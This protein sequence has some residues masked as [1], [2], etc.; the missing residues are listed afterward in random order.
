MVTNS[1]RVLRPLLGFASC[2]VLAG[3][4]VI[5]CDVQSES[6]AA[7]AVSQAG[8]SNKK[9]YS[10]YPR[11]AVLET[12]EEM[13]ADLALER[14]PSDGGGRGWLESGPSEVTVSSRNAWTLAF[15]VGPLGIAEGGV[16]YFMTSPFW[17]WDDHP[18]TFSSEQPGY[19]E[20]STEADGVELE[21]INFGQNLLG[22]KVTGRALV[23]GEVVRFRYGAGAV[24]ARADKFYERDARFWFAVDGDGDGV[25]K[26]VE[27]APSID[28]VTGSPSGLWV[29]IPTST[30]I[31]ESLR[32]TLALLDPRGNA[33]I[34]W[35]GDIVFEDVPAGLEVPERVTLG[36][37]SRGVAA[38]DF[39]A[40]KAGTYTLKAKLDPPLPGAPDDFTYDSNP[41]LASAN[42]R[43]ILWADLH[44]H[45]QLTD[46]TGTPDDFYLYARDVAALDIAVLTDHDHWGIHFLDQRP[47]LWEHIGEVANKY[48]EPGK[49]VSL[50]GYEWTSWIYGHRHV[51]YFTDKGEL[52]SSL[53]PE[54]EN[55]D[56]LW[57]KLKGKDALSFAHHSAG[58]PI[59]T[60]WSFEPDPEIEPVTEIVSVHGSS[61][62]PDSPQRIYRSIPGNFVRD[63]LDSGMRFGFIGSGDSHDG[64][65]GLAHL[66]APSGGLAAILAEDRTRESVL[67]ALRARRVY[68]TNGQRILLQVSVSGHRMGSTIPADQERPLELSVRVVGTG[69]IDA[70][71]FIWKNETQ[72][73]PCG[74]RTEIYLPPDEIDIAPGDYLY[75]RVRQ[76]DGGVAWSSPFYAD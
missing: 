56:Q 9:E 54:T 73:L 31:G 41:M 74:G 68:A 33:W 23:E 75:L 69:P 67:E 16:I 4:T 11:T 55:P 28:V 60:D 38:V 65:P 48:Y 10:G 59:A 37:E 63:V 61:E 21:A 5:A 46:G 7:K 53:A 18:Q 76:A 19:T 36:A 27:D 42:A 49:F 6:G 72:T 17:G 20:I 47:D 52:Y 70:I 62:A 15:E 24:G 12:L 66:A 13:R 64:H 34:D 43:P 40:V 51:V 30:A 44:G 32:M 50:L 57:A 8:V 39:R 45:S 1:N 3:L 14:H 71:D 35:R 25:R 29:T 2:L 22:A 26:L 58:G